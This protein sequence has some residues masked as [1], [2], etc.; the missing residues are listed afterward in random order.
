MPILFLFMVAA[1]C[2][3]VAW[4]ASPLG[5]TPC[6]SALATVGLVLI[7]VVLAL[8]VSFWVVRTLRADER[9]RPLVVTRYARLRRR[10]RMFNLIAVVA[11]I[12]LCGWGW[13]VWHSCQMERHDH[14]I[15]FP[16]AELLVPAPYFLI[17]FF[18]WMVYFPAE[19]Q[20]HRSSASFVPPAEPFA[21][22]TF[23]EYMIFHVR[24]FAL[25]MLLPLGL[26]VGQ[27]SITRVAPELALSTGFQIASLVGVGLLFLYLPR[28]V[29]PI[30]GL[31]SLPRGP[32]R[33]QLEAICQRLRFRYTDLLLW[34]TRGAVANAMVLGMIPSARYV[35]FTDCLL[36]GLDAEEQEAVLGH[37]VGHIYHCH[38]AYYACFLMLSMLTGSVGLIA[39][40]PSL[41]QSG[42]ASE[43]H[44]W[45]GWI[46]VPPVLLMAVYIF[47]VFGLL[48]RRC[49]RQADL[50][51]CRVASCGNPHCTG[52]T[53][54]T[55]RSGAGGAICPTGVRAMA[56]A[57]ERVMIL[58]GL[59]DRSRTRWQR[60][61][62]RIR[63]W[64]HGPL[65]E[66]IQFIM[67]LLEEPLLA[68]RTDRAVT[69]FRHLLMLGLILLF[70]TL[71]S[72]VGWGT[73]WQQL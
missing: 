24:Q 11:A 17:I 53:E 22:W 58:N 55:V 51:G 38:I 43:L 33:E 9:R 32:E 66:R 64:Q 31:Q 30:L 12:G 45:E 3:P 15:L 59:R 69:R 18:N 19:R 65:P 25:L 34:P 57:L 21:Y 73:V 40:E 14:P 8:A 28:V 49:E 13:T 47:V 4:P 50:F 6:Q 7:P 1:T 26:F 27:Q 46:H 54:S 39:L 62:S 70:V 23:P 67:R 63:A 44:A 56:Q 37:E 48:S 5:L 20:L 2:L 61:L 29:K 36:R 72:W 41:T 42:L 16:G 52:H 68:E 71:G 35:V 60:M 10:L